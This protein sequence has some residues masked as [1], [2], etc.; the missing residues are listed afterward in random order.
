M[1]EYVCIYARPMMGGYEDVLLVLKDRP[2]W[3]QGYCN[4]PGGKIEE[5]ETPEEAAIRELEEESGLKPFCEGTRLLG[6]ITGT[7]GTVYCVLVPV[8]Y[9]HDLKPRD[10]ETESIF[11]TSWEEIRNHELL[12]PNLRVAIPLIKNNITNWK[13]ID[14]GPTWDQSK[15][16]ISLEIT[17]HNKATGEPCERP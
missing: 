2:P 6:E 9:H 12:I 8:C 15:H 1:Q 5:G 3:Q 11:W 7:W 14:E 10:G 13:I 16:T 4:L 17:S